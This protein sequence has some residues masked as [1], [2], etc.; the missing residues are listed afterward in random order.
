[1]RRSDL[2]TPIA[3]VGFARAVAPGDGRSLPAGHGTAFTTLPGAARGWPRWVG[4]VDERGEGV[5]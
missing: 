4:G 2:F 5:Y 1:M 3:G